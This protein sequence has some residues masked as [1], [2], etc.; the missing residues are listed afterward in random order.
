MSG[1]WE[2]DA[3]VS[4]IAILVDG[5]EELLVRVEISDLD[6]ADPLAAAFIDLPSTEA[7]RIALE[8]LAAAG[9]ADWQTE[10]N[11]CPQETPVSLS[12][13]TPITSTTLAP[14]VPARARALAARLA[15]LFEQDHQIVLELNNAHHLLASANDRLWSDPVVDRLSVHGQIHRA[16]CAYQSASEQ[17]RQLAVDVGELTQQLADTLTAAGHRPE[18]AQT[19]NVHQLAAGAWQPTQQEETQR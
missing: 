3:A 6:D 4:P 14:A 2:I 17:R 16:F 13:I 19:A 12:D 7:R 8:I 11:G 18:H 5:C 15:A 9:D 10:Q 1:L